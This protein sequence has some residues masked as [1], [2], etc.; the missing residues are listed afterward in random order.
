M[1]AAWLVTPPPDARRY[2]GDYGA[3]GRRHNRRARVGAGKRD[4]HAVRGRLRRIRMEAGD[5]A[6]QELAGLLLALQFVQR[7]QGLPAGR[8]VDPAP[9]ALARMPFGDLGISRPGQATGMAVF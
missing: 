8:L 1:P 4:N 3:L 5:D 6:L 2:S 9:T 7:Q